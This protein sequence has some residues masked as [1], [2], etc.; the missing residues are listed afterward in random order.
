MPKTL[1][2]L[3]EASWK[4]HYGRLLELL[5]QYQNIRG[6]EIGKAIHRLDDATGRERLGDW[7]RIKSGKRIPTQLLLGE[8]AAA[9][10][11]PYNILRLSTG[12]VDET[13]ES[14]YSVAMRPEIP[15]WRHPIAPRRAALG[16]LF[17][18]FPNEEMHIDNR[19]SLRGIL[20]GGVLRLNVVEDGGY[21]TGEHWNSTWLYPETFKPEHLIVIK[22][23]G[24][25][26]LPGSK[27][28][29]ADFAPLT[30]IR[31]EAQ[32]DAASDIAQTILSSEPE[33][34][35]RQCMLYEA[36][37][38]LHASSL[39]LS[40]RLDHAKDIVH[41]WAD[42]LDSKTAREVRQHLQQWVQRSLTVE[43]ARWI[44]RGSKGDPPNRFWWPG[45][46]P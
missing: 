46:R 31:A 45:E 11:V 15:E 4:Q 32:I 38:V 2:I 7:S 35:P 14:C 23:S 27:G 33:T 29:A 40:M 16:L 24:V 1:S 25:T 10:R 36:L 6:A 17:S 21:Q 12:Y 22:S 37:H 3:D 34:I 9:L 39:S 19:L 42:E 30:V 28:E 44:K 20:L 13:I 8:L 18:L 41:A 5:A 26:L 43:A